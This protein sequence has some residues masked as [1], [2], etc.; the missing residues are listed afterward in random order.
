VD[1]DDV[2]GRVI[3]GRVA[4][5]F[6]A[7]CLTAAS[8]AALIDAD[9]EHARPPKTFPPVSADLSGTNPPD[10]LGVLEDVA[11]WVEGEERRERIEREAEE[12]RAADLR[13]RVPT[14]A[15]GVAGD[16]V[17]LAAEW[18]LPVYVIQRESGCRLD[19]YN[20]GG[21]GGRGCVGLAQLDAGHFAAVSPW[22]PNVPGACYG[23]DPSDVGDQRECA[24]R[25]PASAWG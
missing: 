19:A 7:L 17:A 24:S 6:V 11:V 20:P 16:C 15:T 8:A 23:L 2:G 18:G 4:L 5:A 14:P 9:P 13:R 1:A 21:C 10:P 3:A 12:A 25:L 22:N